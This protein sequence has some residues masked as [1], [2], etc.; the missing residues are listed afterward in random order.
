MIQKITK[1]KKILESRWRRKHTAMKIQTAVKMINI[2]EKI[3][4]YKK[5]I[6]KA[7]TTIK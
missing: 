3:I 6:K 2:T 1:W 7:I 4:N 5:I